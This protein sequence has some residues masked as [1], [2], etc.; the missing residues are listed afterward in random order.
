MLD[1]VV[2]MT[3]FVVTELIESFVLI[4][5]SLIEDL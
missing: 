2:H 4:R 3:S 5:M 1:T